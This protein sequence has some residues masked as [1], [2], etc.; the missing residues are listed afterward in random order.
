MIRSVLARSLRRVPSATLAPAMCIAPRAFA[1][2]MS[3][4]KE[5][6]YHDLKSE[7]DFNKRDWT[8][9]G[10]ELDTERLDIDGHPV[11]QKWETPYMGELARIATSNG[12]RVLEVGFGMAIS[13]RAVQQYEHTEHIIMEANG[14]VYKRLVAFKETYPKVTPMGPA[15]WQDSV[16][17]LE[18]GCI[19]G[20]LY[21]T[22][23]LNAEE[24]HTHQFDFLKQARRLLRPGGVLTYCNLTSLGVLKNEYESWEELFEK[25]QLP[26][27]EAAGYTRDEIKGFEVVKV[28]PTADCEYYQHVSAMAPIIIRGDK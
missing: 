9:I 2:T 6:G 10:E 24:Q 25:T 17:Q 3:T 19:D 23:P 22:Y 13:A 18:D 11:M 8:G 14:D 28:K 4:Q 5:G 12:G 16:D 7:S 21:D 26:H 27:L 20:I 1:K 15:L